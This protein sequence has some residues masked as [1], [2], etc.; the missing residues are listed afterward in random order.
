MPDTQTFLHYLQDLNK[1]ALYVLNKARN[2]NFTTLLANTASRSGVLVAEEESHYILDS[3]CNM[4]FSKLK[5]LVEHVQ[6]CEPAWRKNMLRQCY[7]IPRVIE[8]QLI[9]DQ[10]ETGLSC[11]KHYLNPYTPCKKF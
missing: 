4:T 5:A 11:L 9:V 6:W 2:D 3:F 1:R 8:T 7:Y 10:I